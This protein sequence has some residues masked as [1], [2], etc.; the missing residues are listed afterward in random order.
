MPPI[1]PIKPAISPAMVTCP[2]CPSLVREDRLARHIRRYHGVLAQKKGP[3]DPTRSERMVPSTAFLRTPCSCGGTNENCFKCGGWG[4]IDPIGEGRST[5]VA[6]GFGREETYE[7]RIEGRRKMLQLAPV[8]RSRPNQQ[9]QICGIF[10][11]R[12]S[13]HNAKAHPTH[14]ADSSVSAPTISAMPATPHAM[15]QC[16][17]CQSLVREDHM[18]RHLK[19]VH[20]EPLQRQGTR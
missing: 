5:P 7:A 9:C 17:Q 15:M 4:Y 12:L 11:R 19:R 10:V 14:S 18:A 16:A 2:H 8:P 3:H 20:G 13:R 6:T 1:A